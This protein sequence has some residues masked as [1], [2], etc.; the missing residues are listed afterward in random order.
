MGNQY[1][2]AS[3]GTGA[4]PGSG[5]GT[6]TPPDASTLVDALN[7]LSRVLEGFL[8]LATREVAI[9]DEREREYRSKMGG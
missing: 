8:T 7:R 1:A 2:P 9:R 6:P 4:S 3:T 5:T